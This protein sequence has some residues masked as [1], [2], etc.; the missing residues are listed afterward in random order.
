MEGKTELAEQSYRLA[1]QNSEFPDSKLLVSW[2]RLLEAQGKTPT[3]MAAY[4]RAALID[5]DNEE[6][7]TRL[8]QLTREN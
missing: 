2:G 6:I 1:I 3:A 7:K 4:Q 8:K 5:P